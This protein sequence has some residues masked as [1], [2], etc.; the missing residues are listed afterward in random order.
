M[1]MKG[2]TDSEYNKRFPFLWRIELHRV[3]FGGQ[4]FRNFK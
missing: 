3:N 4:W 1:E 2:L